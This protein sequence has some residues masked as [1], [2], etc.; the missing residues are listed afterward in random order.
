MSGSVVVSIT[1]PARSVIFRPLDGE[2]VLE[3][4]F[5]ADSSSEVL[6]AKYGGSESVEAA[7]SPEFPQLAINPPITRRRI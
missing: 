2:R 6:G 5:E 1:Y 4:S 7:Y 3:R